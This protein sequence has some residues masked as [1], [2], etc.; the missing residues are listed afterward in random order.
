MGT[1]EE[2][3]DERHTF[4]HTGRVLR[5]SAFSLADKSN[6]VV[7]TVMQRGKSCSMLSR[8]RKLLLFSRAQRQIRHDSANCK[9]GA[10]KSV[11][12]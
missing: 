8:R 12:S 4:R 9:C 1:R 5:Y 2:E 11:N 6:H 3:A 10:K 7:L